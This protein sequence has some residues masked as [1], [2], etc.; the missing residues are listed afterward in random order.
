[1]KALIDLLQRIRQWHYK[2]LGYVY[3][4][5]KRMWYRTRS[6]CCN[7]TVHGVTMIKGKPISKP[8]TA[9]NDKQRATIY[10]RDWCDDCRRECKTVTEA[11][12]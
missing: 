2:R 8:Y 6:V 1:M 11:V 3:D 12:V 7:A 10:Y 9:Y 5:G 4:H